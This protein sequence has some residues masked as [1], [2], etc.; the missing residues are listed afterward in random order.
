MGGTD[1]PGR[2]A[3]S[4]ARRK[5]TRLCV[6]AAALVVATSLAPPPGLLRAAGSLG[7]AGEQ[8]ALRSGVQTAACIP[9]PIS[10]G[11]GALLPNGTRD[12]S[13]S[14][15]WTFQWSECPGASQYRLVV[16]HRGAQ[17]P[18]IDE[19]ALTTPS[20]SY[21]SAGAYID[22]DSR[23]DWVWT[24]EAFVDA[25]WSGPSAEQRFDVAAAH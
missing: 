13:G 15:A 22:D 3:M 6:L 24:V 4:F 8:G 1:R 20:F 10:P 23:S 5:A 12:G 9:A 11:D 17:F 25:G 2:F 7:S 14:I 21:L 19:S 18:L 16:R